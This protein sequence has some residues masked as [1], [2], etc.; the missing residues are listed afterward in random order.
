V[1]PEPR[2]VVYLINGNALV[3]VGTI[4]EIKAK[5]EA[6]GTSMFPVDADN[7]LGQAERPLKRLANLS[8]KHP[9]RHRALKT[10]EG[11]KVFH[12][13]IAFPEVFLR[14]RAGFD[15]LL[16]DPPWDKLHIEEHSFWARHFPGLRGLPARKQNA[17][18][19][20]FRRS[21]PDLVDSGFY[22]RSSR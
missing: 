18:L 15:V 21:R 14:R 1:L 5:F 11:P 3:G 16:G 19:N 9:S 17:E 22:A 7:L 13:P 10:L 6:A 2:E 12:F 8:E 4:A 20:R